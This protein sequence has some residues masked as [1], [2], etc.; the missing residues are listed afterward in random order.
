MEELTIEINNNNERSD[1]LDTTATQEQS[2]LI[3]Q[4]QKKTKFKT[5]SNADRERVINAHQ[6]GCSP[7][8][9]AQTLNINVSTVYSI[10]KKIKNTYQVEAS[11][12]GGQHEKKIRIE[13]GN[14]IR[15]WIDE[16]ATISLKKKFTKSAGEF[17]P[18]SE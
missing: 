8:I 10:I 4:T 9:I 11:K 3:M 7:A 18:S 12:R 6:K 13:I 1:T 5:T 16:D 15:E 17:Q 14:K 2:S